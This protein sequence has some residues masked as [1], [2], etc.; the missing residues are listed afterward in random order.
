M[1]NI[2]KKKKKDYYKNTFD[3]MFVEKL[4]ELLE[5]NPNQF[6]TLWSS[7]KTVQSSMLNKHGDI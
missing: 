4:I 1:F 6:T 2:F 3:Q 5:T 7:S